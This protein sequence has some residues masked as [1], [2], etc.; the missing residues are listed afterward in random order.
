[1]AAPK[2]LF[3]LVERFDRNRDEYK[4]G[5]F[6]ETQVRVEF[7]D[8]LMSL[9]G[10]D[11][12]N[13]QGHSEPYRE[14]IHEDRVK[15]GGG[16][17][18]PDYGFYIGGDRKF[19]L[20][21][22]KPSV[23]IA[24]DVAPAVQLRRYAWSAK[25]PLSILTDFEEFAVYDCRFEPT[26]DDR[27]DTA[28]LDFFTYDQLADRW[29]DLVAL[30]SR[31]AVLNGSLD[32]YAEEAKRK[33]GTRTVDDAFLREI[34]RWR[35]SLARDLAARNNLNQ[36]QLN[37]AVQMNIDRIIFLRMAEDRGVEEYGKLLRVAENSGVYERLCNV[38]R[39]ADDRYNSG[40]FHFQSERG[41]EEEPDRLTLGL[42][43]DDELLS[44]IIKS[45]YYPDSSYEFSVLPVDVLGQVYEQFLGSV[46]RLEDADGAVVE[47]KPEVRK[48][49][50]VYY[51]P[52]YI[53][54]YIVENTVGRLLEGKRP[55]S[56]GGASR[57]K[58]V[59]P[60]CGSGSF[61]IGAYRYLLD[62]HRD[63][64]LEDGPEKHTKELYQG[65]GGQWHLTIDEKKRILLN[66]IYG[67]D[68]DP[69][70]VE[71]TKLSLLLKVLEGESE[72]SITRQ[73]AL[74]QERALPDLDNNIK[75]G[76]SLI[77]P[78]FYDEQDLT[79][80]ADDDFYRINV[81]DWDEAFPQAFDSKDPG[82]DAVI[83]NPPYIRIQA[84]KE[85]AP[86]E[87]EHYKKAYRTAAKGNYDIYVVFV[88]QGL[89]LLNRS[90]RVGYI[91]PHKFFNAKYGQPAREL[92]SEGNHL[93]EIVHFGDEQVFAGATTYTAL[94]FL[95]RAGAESFR[96]VKAEDLARWRTV[97]EAEEGTI[98]AEQATPEEWNFVIGK[99]ASLFGRLAEMPVTLEQITDRIF[100]GIKTSADKIY[101]VNEVERR[102]SS[103]R[104]YSRERDAEYWLEEELLHPLV[105][106]G[107]SKRFHLS[108]TDRLILFPYASRGED[109]ARLIPQHDMQAYYPLTWHYLCDN[110]QYL[111]NRER[112]KMR[113]ENWYA[114]GRNQA[115]DVM[116]LPKIFTPDIAD[117]ASYSI[118]ESGEAFF[119]GGVSGGYG[120]LPKPDYARK[121]VLGL[122]NSRL[123]EWYIRNTATWMRG[124][125]Y[126]YESRFIRHL[127]ICPID[128]RDPEER[129]H[130]EQLVD[131][132]ARMLELHGKLE[133]AK[134]ERE[135]K[136][137]GQQIAATD[138]QI[139]RLVY[140]LY[141]LNDEEIA[142][143]EEATPR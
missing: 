63:R 56:R 18:A 75:C 111:E 67:V 65:S 137:I 51:T 107:D 47:Q 13:Q 139:D 81:F 101:I 86:L 78:Q 103:V 46:I 34:E 59:D 92:L 97:R 12:H 70:A 23:D 53:V 7:I 123:L 132:V 35:S 76:N 91:L 73:L 1:M 45:L 141:G 117:R 90:G 82:F 17:K 39:E 114:Y 6:N 93:S 119:T 69:Q 31:E 33:R 15:V 26:K 38:F 2:E 96:F 55:G 128:F 140:E 74:I 61:L 27:P 134:I 102:D 130:Y 115:L 95:D 9:L 121:F 105:K 71:V 100:Q 49:G 113:G 94:L 108:R 84:L 127:P 3:E 110:K 58:I 64:Y 87:V 122:L 124:G 52:T 104:V 136:I 77:G 5:R 126:S 109:A 62:W 118:D 44:G 99:G 30:F 131:L 43:V 98:P 11:L 54:D 24:G 19:F 36:R 89:S 28:R 138:R 14:V 40:L 129:K 32:E 22:K 68:I 37:H 142:V 29:D 25:L 20:E 10:W 112:G 8:P 66:N 79:L 106:G 85:F 4:S 125:Y 88:E 48:A 41:R 143:V 57:L 72:A 42:A 133:N 21:A 116:P 60:A 16:T 80:F 135:R 83:G 120:I 50:G